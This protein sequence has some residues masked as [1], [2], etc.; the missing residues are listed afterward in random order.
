[1]PTPSP[2][3][4]A[5]ENSG[6]RFAWMLVS[7]ILLTVVTVYVIALAVIADARIEVVRD[8]AYEAGEA[9]DAEVVRWQR[10]TEFGMAIGLAPSGDGGL[11]VA[12]TVTSPPSD[13]ALLAG[14][15]VSCY[16]ADD[17]SLD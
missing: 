11:S 4:S 5:A 17:S 3:A 2:S 15:R 9:H 13:P 16:R 6:R 8:D 12:V 14:G 10:G 7:G 1:M